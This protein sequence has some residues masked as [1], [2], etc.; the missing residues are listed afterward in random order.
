MRIRI[1]Y[2]KAESMIYTST[3]DIQK[4]WERSFRRAGLRPQYSQGF[5]PQPRIQIACPLPLGFIGRQE[6]I[7]IWLDEE[8]TLAQVKKSLLPKLPEG[9]TIDDLSVIDDKSPSTVNLV[10]YAEYIVRMYDSTITAASLAKAIGQQLERESIPRVRNR[11]SYDLRPLIQSVSI[12]EG[13][14]GAAEISMRLSAGSAKTGR[15]EELLFELGYR[16]S[17]FSVERTA[18]ILKEPSS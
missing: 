15:P 7:D 10:A 2:A 4:M 11:K 8:Q 1:T 14:N 6:L 18:L 9:I 12:S 13:K 16:L 3:L 17:D 5:H